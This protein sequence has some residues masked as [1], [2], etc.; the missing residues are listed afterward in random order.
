MAAVA[1]SQSLKER[2]RG[3]RERLILRAAEELLLERG[4]HEMSIDDIAARVGISK[5]TVYLHFASKEDLALA[6]LDQG[7]RNFHHALEATLASE[8]T[9]R[10]KLHAIIQQVYGGMASR[11]FQLVHALFQDPALLGRMVEARRALAGRWGEPSRRIVVVMEEGK[12][13][14]DF[15]I[16]I[17]TSVMLSL[18]WSLLSPHTYR[19][20]V[21][22]EGLSL[23]DV[24]EH[25]SRFFFKGVAPDEDSG[26]RPPDAATAPGNDTTGGHHLGSSPPGGA[27]AD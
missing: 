19:T 27:M 10:E 7:L 24:A 12:A 5:G 15:A 22:Q 4:Y 13:R 2:Q 1:R 11:H 9:P 18:F 21:V 26:G 17:P 6:L 8:A 16:T 14:G 3:E 25:V 20:L 23:E